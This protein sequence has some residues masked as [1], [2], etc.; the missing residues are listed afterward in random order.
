MATELATNAPEPGFVPSP[1]CENCPSKKMRKENIPHTFKSKLC[2]VTEGPSY[3]F[4]VTGE[5][6]AGPASKLFWGAVKHAQAQFP[7]E[8][9]PPTFTI[10][11]ALACR[12]GASVDISQTSIDCCNDRL[13][14]EIYNSDCDYILTLGTAAFV[15]VTGRQKAGIGKIQGQIFDHEVAGRVRH[16][17]PAYHP[18][19][20]AHKPNEL[21]N[22]IE[23]VYKAIAALNGVNVLK[24]P[25]PTTVEIAKTEFDI[26]HYILSR[27]KD[28]TQYLD[29]DIETSDLAFKSS[30]VL[31][32]GVT[33]KPGYGFVIPE[34]L[35]HSAATQVLLSRPYFNYIWH[36]G[37]FDINFLNYNG[38]RARVDEDTILLHYLLNENSGTHGLELLAMQLLGA[39]D[40]KQALKSTLEKPRDSYAKLEISLLHKYQAQDV[41]YGMQVFKILKAQ[42]EADPQLRWAYKNI[43]IPAQNFLSK[44]ELKGLYTHL[45]K[46]KAVDISLQEQLV[47]VRAALQKLAEP[48]W[49]AETYVEAV[50]AKS[51]PAAFNPSSP[52]QVSWLVYA[53]LKCKPTVHK[54][55]TKGVPDTG[56]AT[57]LS[58]PNKPE[59]VEKLLELRKLQKLH[60]TYVVSMLEKRDTAGRI[61]STFSLYGTA[62]GRL[63]STDPN[64]QNIPRDKRIKTIFGAPPGRLL[65]ECDY[66]SAELRALALYSND[67][68]L[69]KVF[70]EGKDL[71]DETALAMFGEGFTKNQRVQAKMINFGI[72]YGRGARTIAESCKISQHEAQDSID[73]WLRR[74]PYAAEYLNS[75]RK[76]VKS[77]CVLF[78]QFGRK[79]RYPLITQQNLNACQNEACNF[80]IQS[81]A[82]DFT[83]LTGI[84]IAPILA[85]MDAYIVNLVHDSLLVDLPDDR[86]TAE[87]IFELVP[88]EMERTPTLYFKNLPFGFEADG[89]IG[90][91]W[92]AFKESV[93]EWFDGENA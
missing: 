22:F 14:A 48:Y 29:C 91:N 16:V 27:R 37:K 59:L 77:G 84:R 49:D 20:L 30:H 1:H 67:P 56:E 19:L 78:T 80:A 79:K 57:L 4:G 10:T 13:M 93:A 32:I 15:A 75:R 69:V 45:D 34:E 55:L 83:L 70:Q 85:K 53:V 68:F 62:T 81:I 42:V 89:S 2:V 64:L 86:A 90:T 61:H 24:K 17:I 47:E 58:I 88:M 50:G 92:G 8:E 11:A 3:N 63:S 60:S 43:L 71:H 23:A 40:Y 46:L 38:H 5:L 72:M 6:I 35:V 12:Q 41:D 9:K 65:I 25:G 26:L 18:A 28:G 74:M 82:S 54:T 44:V 31:C 52:K 36:N 73:R 33:H 87:K 21:G 7:C 76:L 51:T 66:K 39:A